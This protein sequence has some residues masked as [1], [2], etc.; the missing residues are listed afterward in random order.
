MEQLHDYR[1]FETWKTRSS[2]QA[3]L[4]KTWDPKM[5]CGKMVPSYF[6]V[7][8]LSPL[9]PLKLILGLLGTSD[10]SA[11]EDKDDGSDDGGDASQSDSG[12]DRDRQKTEAETQRQRQGHKQI[13]RQ[14]TETGQTD[15]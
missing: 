2:Y 15:R 1:F 10:V 11:V 6:V 4:W 13:D 5:L 8:P 12:R 7:E 3:R 9:E 14:N